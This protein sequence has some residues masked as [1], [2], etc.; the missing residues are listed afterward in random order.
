MRENFKYID[1]E[2]KEINCYKWTVEEAKAVVYIVHGM[3]ESCIRYD[4]L[5]NKLNEKGYT[6]YAHDHRGHGETD[7]GENRGYIADNE[8]FEKLAFNLNELVNN[9]KKEN[10][11]LEIILLAHSMGTFV[12]LR[13]LELYNKYVKR[14]ILSGSNGKLEPIARLGA[15]IAKCEIIF[16]GRKHKS[17]LMDKLIFGG[18]NKK[19]K[20]NRT[21]FDWVC[22]NDEAIDEYI[23]REDCGFI[24]SASFYYDLINGVNRLHKKKEFSKINKEISFY[25]FSG[26]SDPVGNYGKGV[27]K[28][29]SEM[30]SYGIDNVEYVLYKNGRHEMLNEKNRDEVIEGVLNFLEK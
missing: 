26:E 17:K 1:S 4:Y 15:I 11:N 25:I 6:V 24:C 13:Y 3:A 29:I 19:F 5:A 20:P 22:S 27:K 12:S 28:L 2:E 16:C 14:V 10:P 7:K 18:H 8:G 23:S 9:A 21:P 30:K